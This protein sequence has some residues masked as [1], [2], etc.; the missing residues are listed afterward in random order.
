M[1]RMRSFFG[2]MGPVLVIG[3]LAA[4]VV[5][6]LYAYKPDEHT[7]CAKSAIGQQADIAVHVIRQW[8]G[9]EGQVYT[10]CVEGG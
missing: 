9:R 5:Y 2:A 4:F 6:S 1:N 10:S 7:S 3:G 8:F